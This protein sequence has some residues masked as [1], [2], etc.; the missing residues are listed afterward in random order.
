MT[1]KDKVKGVIGF[2]FEN[3]EQILTPDNQVVLDTIAGLGALAI[4]RMEVQI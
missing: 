3:P 2:H 4:E 1:L